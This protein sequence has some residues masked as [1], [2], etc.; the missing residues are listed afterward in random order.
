MSG[1]GELFIEMCGIF[2]TLFRT[3]KERNGSRCQ[4]PFSFT[5][6]LGDLQCGSQH[7]LEFLNLPMPNVQADVQGYRV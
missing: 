1:V 7:V 5:R 4:W 2:Y 6:E 3:A